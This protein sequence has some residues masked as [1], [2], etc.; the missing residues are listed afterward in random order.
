MRARGVANGGDVS[1]RFKVVELG[2][3][4]DEEIEKALNQ[5][6]AEGWTLDSMHFAM[7]ESSKRPSMAFMSFTREEPE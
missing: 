5:W 7:R 6:A 2:N 3:V 4:T 1:T